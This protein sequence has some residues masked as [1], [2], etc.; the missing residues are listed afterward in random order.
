[1]THIC[2]TLGLPVDEENIARA[3]EKHAWENLP[4]DKKG[5][6]KFYR[7]ASPGGWQDD[8][9]PEQAETVKRITAPLLEKFYPHER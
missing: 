8:L 5:E 7:K 9:T 1:M 2:A 6:G 3:V 4:E